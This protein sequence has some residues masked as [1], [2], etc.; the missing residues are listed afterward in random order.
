VELGRA[1]RLD[2]LRL[3]PA[4]ETQ[5]VLAADHP[6]EVRIEKDS[7]EVAVNLFFRSTES[8]RRGETLELQIRD[9]ET[10][11]QFPPGGIKLTV[12]RDI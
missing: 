12:G 7:G 1:L 3:Q 5:S 4:G 11:E 8:F 9:A 10:S 2:V 6:K